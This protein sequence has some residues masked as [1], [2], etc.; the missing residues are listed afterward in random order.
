MK[1]TP[2]LL[3][4]VVLIGFTAPSTAINKAYHQAAPLDS[5]LA[6]D[7]I[8]PYHFIV[9]TMSFGSPISYA[10]TAND[11]TIN[12]VTGSK[13]IF[14]LNNVYQEQNLTI[15]IPPEGGTITDSTAYRI[16]FNMDST[17]IIS[18]VKTK[19]W[20]DSSDLLIPLDSLFFRVRD[21][22]ELILYNEPNP[23][24]WYPEVDS[25]AI[26]VVLEDGLSLSPNGDDFFEL[27]DIRGLD[28]TNIYQLSI[29][30]A[31]KSLIFETTDKFVKWDC[32]YPNSDILVPVGTY[33]YNIVADADSL[34]GQFVIQY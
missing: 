28:S 13:I 29:Y 33:L 25:N 12:Y 6:Y 17:K 27:F 15:T 22:N 20:T 14:Y 11:T 31:N 26:G 8:M 16:C 5:I 30:D 34:N 9:N 32:R 1:Y 21:N 24:A 7:T 19:I 10:I 18:Q 3:I 23:Y 2:I 4:F